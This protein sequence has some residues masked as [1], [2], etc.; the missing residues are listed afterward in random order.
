MLNE[1]KHLD[2]FIKDR[3]EEILRYTQKQRSAEQS[4]AN[5]K[6]SLLRSLLLLLWRIS[7]SN[8]LIQ[9]PIHIYLVDSRC[10]I[11]S[12]SLWVKI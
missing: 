9:L 1:V 5:D 3:G 12:M 7:K 4:G 2:S 11:L 6:K 10:K 8:V